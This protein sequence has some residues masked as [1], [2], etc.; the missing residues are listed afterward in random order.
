M[1]EL[2]ARYL[3]LSPHCFNQIDAAHLSQYY[4]IAA[5]MIL[6]YDHLLTLDDEVRF[7]VHLEVTPLID[8]YFEDQIYL[9]WKEIAGCARSL[10]KMCFFLI[11]SLGR[12]LALRCCWSRLPPLDPSVL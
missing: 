3:V 7:I 5:G 6:F 1:L 2:R 10:K 9:V 12:I 4:G 8:L 11:L